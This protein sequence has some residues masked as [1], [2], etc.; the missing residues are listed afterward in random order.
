MGGGNLAIEY[1]ENVRRGTRLAVELLL[2]EYAVYCPFIDLPYWLL[3]QK[4]EE[5]PARIIYKADL[6]ML[7]RMDA[8]LL[9]PG[10]EGS[11]GVQGEIAL[12]QS[13][14]IPVFEDIEA[15]KKAIK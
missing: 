7:E 11:Y 2:A 10:W 1:C 14:G 12:A 5:L 6:A 13:L 15:L 3:L 9:V 4:G 8:V